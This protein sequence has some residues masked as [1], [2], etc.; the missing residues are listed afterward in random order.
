[1]FLQANV[2]N[3]THIGVVFVCTVATIV[4]ANSY[5]SDCFLAETPCFVVGGDCVPSHLANR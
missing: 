4:G 1:M 2:T 3:V 5:L